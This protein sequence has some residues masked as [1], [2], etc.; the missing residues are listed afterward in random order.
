MIT[1]FTGL[2][3]FLDNHTSPFILLVSEMSVSLYYLLSS[4][5]LTISFPT[6]TLHCL[7][8][9]PVSK[10]NSLYEKVCKSAT[11]THVCLYNLFS[12]QTA[13]LSLF[14]AKDNIFFFAL[15]YTLFWL[16]RDKLIWQ[17]LYLMCQYFFLYYIPFYSA[18]TYTVISFPYQI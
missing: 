15:Y 8:F 12:S 16:V 9:P 17:F 11:C 13:E 3:D 5:S 2:L 1:K 14:L 4:K 18:Q 6:L 7:L 10:Q